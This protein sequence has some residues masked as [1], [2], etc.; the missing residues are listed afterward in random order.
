MKITKYEIDMLDVKSADAF[1][2]IF[3]MM[4]TTTKTISFLSMQEIII[5]DQQSQILS[6][7][8]MGKKI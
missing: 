3:M 5:T 4:M 6:K 8:V 1:L 2:T 7:I